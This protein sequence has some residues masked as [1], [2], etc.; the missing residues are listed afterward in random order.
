MGACAM[1]NERLRRARTL[2]G[3][4][5]TAVA[6]R[7]GVRV[8]VLRA[9]E[10]GR[11]DLLPP[12]IYAR[13][14]IRSYSSA[15]GLDP[16]EILDEIAPSLPE[17]EE[18][19]S[20]IGRLRGVR[21]AP[22]ERPSPNPPAE[23]SPHVETAGA[24]DWRLL[25]ASIIDACVVGLLLVVVVACARIATA[26]PLDVMNRSGAGA[27]ATMGAVFAIAYFLWFGGLMAA[28]AGEYAVGLGEAEHPSRERT[29]L[30]IL[31]ARAFRCAI[32]DLRFIASSGA[33]LRTA[34]R[35]PGRRSAHEAPPDMPLDR[36]PEPCL[37]A[38][39][40]HV[41]GLKLIRGVR[42]TSGR[43]PAAE[44]ARDIADVEDDDLT[45]RMFGPPQD[46]EP[47]LTFD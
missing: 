21:T 27:L 47:D 17:V 2:R 20:A 15:V 9:I 26:M 38:D 13:A 29:T 45:I 1:V 37:Q 19:I 34:V 39:E 24:P 12:G 44:P 43:A 36:E 16:L 8:G 40:P 33:W 14:A 25:I 4:E 28:T 7:I 32:A 31:C 30:G 18:P 42:A 5:L 46:P 3:E 35:L 41:P 22:P 10:D 11:F 23:Q 6:N